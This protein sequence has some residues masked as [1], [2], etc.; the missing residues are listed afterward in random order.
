[1]LVRLPMLRLLVRSMLPPI[2][3]AIFDVATTGNDLNIG[4]P[5]A[6]VLTLGG[7]MTLAARSGVAAGLHIKMAGGSDTNSR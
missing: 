1:M 7:A 2:I 6:P 5:A 4:S 3:A